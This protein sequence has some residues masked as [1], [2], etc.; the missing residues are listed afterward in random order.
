MNS[1]ARSVNFISRRAMEPSYIRRPEKLV[2]WF[3]KTH[4]KSSAKLLKF[5]SNAGFLFHVEQN[6]YGFDSQIHRLTVFPS[7]GR[8]C[9]FARKPE[10]NLPLFGGPKSWFNGSEKRIRTRLPDSCRKLFSCFGKTNMNSSAR[11]AKFMSK[12]W[13]PGSEKRI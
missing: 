5:T 10:R 7:A 8:V 9:G 12:S 2:S 13:F 6:E 3:G 1:S 4:M 11:L